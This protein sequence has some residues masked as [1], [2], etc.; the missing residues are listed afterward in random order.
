MDSEKFLRRGGSGIPSDCSVRL[1][2]FV[3]AFIF[4][5]EE[6]LLCFYKDIA[7]ANRH[8]VI[9]GRSTLHNPSSTGR[10][11]D[12]AGRLA[13]QRHCLRR[14]WRGIRFFSGIYGDVLRLIRPLAMPLSSKKCSAPRPVRGSAEFIGRLLP[15]E[16]DVRACTPCVAEKGER[17]GIQR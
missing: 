11:H 1:P 10:G 13:G 17:L 4:V 12:D 8:P 2:L 7:R 14:P 5:W 9:S 6:I 16:S 15:R 3:C